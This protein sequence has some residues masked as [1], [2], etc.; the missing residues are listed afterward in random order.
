MPPHARVRLMV[1]LRSGGVLGT[2]SG[3]LEEGHLVRVVMA[4]G[5]MPLG[6]GHMARRLR[7][8]MLCMVWILSGPW[9]VGSSSGKASLVV[10]R[11]IQRGIT[12]VR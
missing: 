12:R 1:L 4:R 8:R 3:L 11:G 9:V 10:V 7:R 6:H 2:V 5:C